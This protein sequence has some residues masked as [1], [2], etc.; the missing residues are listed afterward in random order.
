MKSPG[1]GHWFQRRL[2][3]R[4]CV[5]FVAGALLPVALSDWL[6]ITVMD[7]VAEK[8]DGDRRAQTVRATSRQVLDRIKLGEVLL[9]SLADVGS[10]S[11]ANSTAV[12]DRL[13]CPGPGDAAAMP[14]PDAALVSTWRGLTADT[15]KTHHTMLAVSPAEPVSVLVGATTA[16]GRLCVAE[17]KNEFLWEPLQNGADDS[18]WVVHDAGGRSLVHVRGADAMSDGA[19]LPASDMRSH[20]ARLFMGGDGLDEEWIFTQTAPRAHVDWHNEPVAAW[21]GAVAIAT[22]LFVGLVAQNRIRRALAPLERLTAGTVRLAR[23]ETTARVEVPGDDEIGELALSFN[24][25]ASKLEERA[26]QLEYRAVHD[27]L[28]GLTNRFGLHQIL[29]MLLIKS[30]AR[31]ELAVLFIDLDF[32]KNVNDRHGHAVG[33]QV[34][35]MTAQRLRKIEDG[36]LVARKGGDEFVV[37]V[38]DA[39]AEK[40][41]RAVASRLLAELAEPF[42]LADSTHVCGGSIGI[43][44]YPSQAITA[45][46]LLRCADIALYESKRLGRGRFTFFDPALDAEVRRRHDLLSALRAGLERG[47]LIVHYQP[48]LHVES[49]LIESAEAL[50]RWERPGHGLVFPNDFI[51]LAE[52]AGLIGLLGLQVLDQAL[53]QLAKWLKSGLRVKRISVNVSPRQFEGGDLPRQ[54]HAALLRHAVEPSRLELE[55]TESLLCGE[56]SDVKRQLDS[57]RATGVTVAMDDFGTGYSSMS[58]L[59]SLPIDVMKIDRAFVRDLEDDPNAVAIARSIVTLG[60]SLSLRLVAEGIETTGQAKLLR[61]MECDEFQGYLFGMPMSAGDFEASLAQA[62]QLL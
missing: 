60:R 25:M 57:L 47:E 48:R 1:F 33:D 9:R 26:A 42:V 46:E 29:E 23:G 28:T 4:L 6:V 15:A 13:W 17:F 16:D 37:I 21:L 43:S 38:R 27:D 20:V 5:L 18:T 36:L 14:E 32:F 40:R 11:R 62:A 50:V 7:G 44:L 41:A 53:A 3:W 54:V 55:I 45:E 39:A 8:L 56:V 31:D 58:L 61:Q 34:L 10:E 2:A 24:A 35:R 51:E 22:L 19:F 12:F 59:R 30:T 49:G 52:T